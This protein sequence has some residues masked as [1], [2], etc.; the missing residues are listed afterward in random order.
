[1]AKVK[2][3]YEVP[4]MQ[5]VDLQ[6]KTRTAKPAGT[7]PA[8]ETSLN[9]KREDGT[10]KARILILGLVL[11]AACQPMDTD[12]DY[13]NTRTGTSEHRVFRHILVA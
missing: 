3:A 7:A 10:M 6:V 9:S 8:T 4:A 1:M 11:L 13:Q 12:F 2:A 5:V